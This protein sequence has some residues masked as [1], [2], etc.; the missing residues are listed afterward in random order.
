M[1]QSN[2]LLMGLLMGLMLPMFVLTGLSVTN[3]PAAWAETTPSGPDGGLRATYL[4]TEYRNQPLG[5]D[6]LQPRLSWILGLP[7]Q[8]EI[9]RG[10]KQTAYQIL[11]ASSKQKLAADQGDLWDSGKVE[12]DETAT[13]PYAGGRL[14]S[15]LA[16]HWKVKVWDKDGRCS[17]WSEPALWTMGLLERSDWLAQW[18][19]YD[20]PGL[21]DGHDDQLHLPP[22][23]VLRKEFSTDR[24]V[25]RTT[26][27]C[28]ALGLYEMR[29]NG[30]RVADDYF[31]PGWT[32]Y[33]KRVYT[34]R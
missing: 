27:Y 13:I 11:V 31:S 7:R 5:I 33:D 1:R 16:C 10:E 6:L 24:R 15:R 8:A 32:D 22:P 30:R 28:S 2:D 21:Q 29:L 19:G 12:S 9:E 23:R 17:G 20:R 25:S 26:L 3:S 18:I 4:R 14:T 34:S